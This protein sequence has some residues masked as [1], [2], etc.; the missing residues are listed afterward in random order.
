MGHPT[1]QNAFWKT[2]TLRQMSSSEWEALCDGCG[3]CCLIKLIDDLTDDLHYT[4]VACKLLDCDSCRCGDYN[5]RKKLVEDCV[6]LSPRLVEELHWMPS[7][8]A[9]RL[10]YEGKDLYW[11]HPLV[12]GNPNT[13]HEAG[14]SVKGRAISEREVK[15]AELPNYINEFL[16]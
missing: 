6:I 9:Y 3:K 2:K 12:S 7:T 5:N 8:C 16:E 13:V 14:I 10:I 1:E 4:T 15:D 11:W